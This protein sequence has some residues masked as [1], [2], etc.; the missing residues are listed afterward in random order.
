MMIYIYDMLWALFY[1]YGVLSEA[2]EI[3]LEF[4]CAFVCLVVFCLPFII[5]WAII[6]R[7]L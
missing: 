3:A 1:N 5:V 2:Q 6:K 7:F 4:W